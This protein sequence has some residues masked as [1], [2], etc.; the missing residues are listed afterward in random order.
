MAT[1]DVL[2]KIL[3]AIPDTACTVTMTQRKK[4]QTD[5]HQTHNFIKDS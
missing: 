4:E 2:N 5:Y 1:G 3:T